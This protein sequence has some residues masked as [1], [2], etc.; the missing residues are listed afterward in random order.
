MRDRGRSGTVGG[1]TNRYELDKAEHERVLRSMNRG[2]RVL[3]VATALSGITLVV[4]V[5]LAVVDLLP[6]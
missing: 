5:V 4:F 1:M 2:V 6:G 3:T